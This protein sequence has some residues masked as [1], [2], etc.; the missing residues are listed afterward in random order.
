MWGR[1]NTNALDQNMLSLN[2]GMI[3]GRRLPMVTT[4]VC[5]MFPAQC[6][7]HGNLIE[8]ESKRHNDYLRA[9]GMFTQKTEHLPLFLLIDLDDVTGPP[10]IFPS[11]SEIPII[12][13]QLPTDSK[14]HGHLCGRAS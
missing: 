11:R 12:L 14:V 10:G 1:D 3:S 13:Y 6:R 4:S 8:V 2:P 5:C 9:V 7:L